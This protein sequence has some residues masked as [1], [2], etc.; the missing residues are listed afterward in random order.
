MVSTHKMNPIPYRSEDSEPNRNSYNGRNSRAEEA[1]RLIPPYVAPVR[2]DIVVKSEQ[3]PIKVLVDMGSELYLEST[4]Q[5]LP[6]SSN[7]QHSQVQSHGL[8]L[9]STLQELPL[10]TVQME[11]SALGIEAKQVFETNPLLPGIILTQQGHYT[12]L[13]SRRQFFEYMSRPYS[14]DLFSKRPLLALYSFTRTNVMVLPIETP[15]VT[16]VELSLQRSPEKVYEPI[17]VQLGTGAYAVLDVYKLLLA[18]SQIHSL[19]THALQQSEIRSKE[20]ATQL[21]SAMQDL[22]KTQ[23]HLIQHEKMSALGQ[24]VAGVAH[25]INNPVNFIYANLNYASQYAHS[26]LNLVQ[27]YQRYYPNP[28]EQIQAESEEI[29]LDFVLADFPKILASMHMGSDRI[30]QIVLSLRNFSRLDESESK[31]VDIH[32]GLDSTLLILQNRLKPNS[33]FPGIVVHK[34]YGSL[35]LVECF[36]GQL[37]QVFMNILNNAI[38]ALEDVQDKAAKLDPD[39]PATYP[40]PKIRISTEMSGQQVTIRII[41]NGPGIPETARQRLFDPFFTTKP[42]GKGTGL[43]LSISH[44]IIVEK[45]KGDLQC[46][47]PSD[48]GTEF[49]IQIPLKAALKKEGTEK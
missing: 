17:V 41:D 48:G 49:V 1:S 15:V 28:V 46:V 34:E 7:G 37:N 42:I 19:A 22:Q 33:D 38:D 16:A 45:H 24:L 13:I 43:G 2:P 29:D 27:L 31:A 40:T 26:L 21:Q 44:Q 11:C 20:Q 35:P 47:S 25:E 5:E 9:E 32:E 30:R 36:P 4:L 6:L 23:F 8:H 18:Q 10:H 39:A 14:L 3:F 12:G